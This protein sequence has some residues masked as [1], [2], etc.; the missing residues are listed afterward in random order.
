[1]NEIKVFMKTNSNGIEFL[2]DDTENVNNKAIEKIIKFTIERKGY[3]RKDLCC[4]GVPKIW[5]SKQAK[6]VFEAL[7]LNI[8]IINEDSAIS[9]PLHKHLLGRGKYSNKKWEEIDTEYLRWI[10]SKKDIKNIQFQELAYTEIKRRNFNFSVENEIVN[11]GKHKGTKW[12]NL[13]KDYLAWLV[14]T[15]EHTSEKYINAKQILDNQG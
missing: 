10:V 13:P 14:K 9:L 12:G 4:F 7:E 15:I 5:N 6:K 8:K 3:F 1:M 11:F 2:Y